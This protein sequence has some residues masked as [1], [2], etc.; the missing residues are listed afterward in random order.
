MY[1][2]KKVWERDDTDLRRSKN[3]IQRIV[4]FILYFVFL[5]KTTMI[6]LCTSIN[7]LK[8]LRLHTK[9]FGIFWHRA[10]FIILDAVSAAAVIQKRLLLQQEKVAV[11]NAA[12][13]TRHHYYTCYRAAVT[14]FCYWVQK[15]WND[16]EGTKYVVLWCTFF[17][18]QGWMCT[19][20]N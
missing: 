2:H 1:T 20:Q 8:W 19:W 6:R 17:K 10:A 13:A 7:V 9:E 16:D 3:W 11:K 12:N 14:S 5:H 4:A 18:Q 15:S